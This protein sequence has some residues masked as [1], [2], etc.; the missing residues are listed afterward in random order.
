[1]EKTKQKIKVVIEPF[2]ARER[3]RQ[4]GGSFALLPAFEELAAKELGDRVGFKIIRY[5]E[6]SRMHDGMGFLLE[7]ET[8]PLPKWQNPQWS[9]RR[10][11][12][13]RNRNRWREWD[14]WN[15]EP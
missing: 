9:T 8:W 1:M 15:G 13:Q 3:E 6:L 5:D 11:W 2:W 14:Q 10:L 12:K 4:N 7:V